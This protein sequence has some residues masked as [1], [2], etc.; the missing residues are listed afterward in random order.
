MAGN[1][2]DPDVMGWALANNPH[3]TWYPKGYGFRFNPAGPDAQHIDAHVWCTPVGASFELFETVYYLAPPA[4]ANLA[5][6]GGVDAE[7]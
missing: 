4:P 6:Q 1:N 3:T 2:Y 5:T 7:Q